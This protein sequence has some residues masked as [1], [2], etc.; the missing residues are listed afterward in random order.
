M[1]SDLC[2]LVAD[3]P[4][5]E[6]VGYHGNGH[7]DSEAGGTHDYASRRDRRREAPDHHG[8]PDGR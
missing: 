5:L 6:E 3:R 1:A 2:N 7:A 4:R 8:I